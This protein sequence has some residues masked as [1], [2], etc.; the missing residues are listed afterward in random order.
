MRCVIVQL[1]QAFKRGVI[2]RLGQVGYGQTD[3]L[4][5]DIVKIEG[6]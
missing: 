6:G 5:R 3:L 4:K 1:G 2:G